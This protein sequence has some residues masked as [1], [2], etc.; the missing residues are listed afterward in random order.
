MIMEELLRDLRD[1]CEKYGM[2][3]AMDS[4]SLL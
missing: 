1:V 4:A 3:V 2:V